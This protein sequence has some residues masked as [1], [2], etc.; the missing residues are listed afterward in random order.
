MQMDM[1][2]N[3]WFLS[4]IGNFGDCGHP[5][6]LKEAA[7]TYFNS[8]RKLIDDGTISIIDDDMVIVDNNI[9]KI[10]DVYYEVRTEIKKS[11]FHEKLMA[12][13]TQIV[14]YEKDLYSQNSGLSN[15]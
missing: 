4:Q 8:V 14:E 10:G 9:M 15:E 7:D 2:D 5:K 3:D 11:D 6:E 13:M 12:A 1:F